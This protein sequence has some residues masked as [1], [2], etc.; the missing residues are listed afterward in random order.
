MWRGR[1][2][3][4]DV[5]ENAGNDREPL[6]RTRNVRRPAGMAL[7]Q[8]E[9][10]H[11][12][13][14]TDLARGVDESVGICVEADPQPRRSVSPRSALVGPCGRLRLHDVPQL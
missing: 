9:K 2:P 4:F 11:E 1:V 13:L 14:T 12:R 3:F 10:G 5:Q 6:T 7:A 8:K